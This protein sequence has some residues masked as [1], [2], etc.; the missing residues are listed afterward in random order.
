M[1]KILYQII[2]SY[3]KN[4]EE[5]NIENIKDF[6]KIYLKNHKLS[7]NRFIVNKTLLALGTN[8]IKTNKYDYQ[9]II[10]KPEEKNLFNEIVQIIDMGN[11]ILIRRGKLGE[12]LSNKG[13]GRKRYKFNQIR[14]NTTIRKSAPK[15][16]EEINLDY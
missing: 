16:K 12:E 15:Q 7:S 3:L 5:P 2:T 1:D 11:K 9:N 4:I 10:I 6:V 13:N 14:K 8:N